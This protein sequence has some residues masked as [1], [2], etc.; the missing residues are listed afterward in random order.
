[1]GWT[2]EQ[3]EEYF[4]AKK[5]KEKTEQLLSFNASHIRIKQFG[6]K[7]QEG[8]EE[9]LEEKS[10]LE[11]TLREET[12]KYNNL[13]SQRLSAMKAKAESLAPNIT[14]EQREE[15]GD[16]TIAGLENLISRPGID[17]LMKRELQE[18]LLELKYQK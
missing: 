16:A 4:W 17:A 3:E 2:Y 18:Q 14:P 12:L 15:Q 8:I 13:D 7:N 11:R 9:L 6:N 10:R 1:M 5:K